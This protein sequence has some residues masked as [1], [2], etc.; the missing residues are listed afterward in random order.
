M[1][2]F[3]TPL[4]DEEV[5]VEATDS[6]VEEPSE[7]DVELDPVESLKAEV[8]ALKSQLEKPAWVND[9]KTIEG[10]IRSAE[11]RL[12]KTEDPAARATLQRDLEAKLAESNDL[13]A[14]MLAGLDDSAFIDPS[15]KQRAATILNENREKAREAAIVE[16]VR[17]ELTPPNPTEATE[18]AR[19]I[20]ARAF[21]EMWEAR[22]ADEDFDP[23][24]TEWASAWQRAVSLYNT[25][26]PFTEIHEAMRTHLK[27]LKD[28]RAAARSR[29]RAKRAAGNGSPRGNGVPVD[30]LSDPNKS[31][32]DKAA[33]LR[34]MGVQVGPV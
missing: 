9:L 28:E 13:L 24:G 20:E 7:E 3:E 30:V 16:R 31:R 27:S 11:A 14:T 4:D 1:S 12:Q 6:E 15:L 19:V 33:F 10:R 29:T 5:E 18:S 32:D 34:S 25:G 17:S 22:I 2:D 8:A 26:R 21:N 23:N